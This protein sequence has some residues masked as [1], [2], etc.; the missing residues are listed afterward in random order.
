MTMA[1][2]QTTATLIDE[3]TPTN[4]KRAVELRTA[5]DY[6]LTLRALELRSE[7]LKKLAKRTSDEGYSREGRAIQADAEAIDHHILPVFRSQRELPLVTEEALAKEIEGALRV[8]IF[9]AFDGLDNPKVVITPGHVHDRRDR[10][11][12]ILTERVL[13]YALEI[14]DESFNQGYAAREQTGEALAMR[15]IAALRTGN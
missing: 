11:I 5:H 7:D 8:A 9:R 3:T 12:D 14:A 1:K 15:P 4:G 13:R 2:D 6:T 10:L